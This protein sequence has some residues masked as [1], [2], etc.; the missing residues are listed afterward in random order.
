VSSNTGHTL[1]NNSFEQASQ[2][3]E[4]DVHFRSNASVQL[5]RHVGFAPDF[6]RMVATQELTLRANRR[7]AAATLRLACTLG[8]T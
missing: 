8:L 2:V 1:P 7:H 3:N 6:G 5:S 4:V